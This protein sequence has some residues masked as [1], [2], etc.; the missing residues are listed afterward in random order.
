MD[1]KVADR[2]QATARA[3]ELGATVPDFQPGHAPDRISPNQWTV[4]LDPEG[5][6][7]CLVELSESIG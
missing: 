2:A 5:H 3:V 6:P 1:L 4:L 7:F